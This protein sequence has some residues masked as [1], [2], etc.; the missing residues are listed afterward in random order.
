MPTAKNIL[1]N[2]SWLSPVFTKKGYREFMGEDFPGIR[3]DGV[4]SIEYCSGMGAQSW[5][6]TVYDTSKL[7][8]LY[9]DLKKVAAKNKKY[10]VRKNGNVIT[11]NNEYF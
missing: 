3:K 6:I 2:G 10:S 4:C 11:I 9:E 5:T 1:E 7:N 8:W